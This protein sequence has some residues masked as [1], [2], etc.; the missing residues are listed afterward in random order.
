MPEGK[1][2]EMKKGQQIPIRKTGQMVVAP[3]R[4]SEDKCE[5]MSKDT[6]N[7]SCSSESS[8]KS[9]TNSCGT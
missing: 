3:R 8:S 4:T 9:G 2:S 6:L 7:V 5:K 1:D